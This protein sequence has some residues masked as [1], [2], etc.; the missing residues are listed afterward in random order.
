MTR[1]CEILFAVR[2]AADVRP[3]CGGLRRVVTTA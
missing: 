2:D 3:S 1:F